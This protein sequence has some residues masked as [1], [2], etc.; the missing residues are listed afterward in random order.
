MNEIGK[1]L[2][3]ELEIQAGSQ[4]AKVERIENRIQLLNRNG[5]SLGT[6]AQIICTAPPPQSA[7]LLVDFPELASRLAEIKLQPCWAVMVT[8]DQPLGIEWAGAFVHDS[9]IAWIGRESSKPGRSQR[10]AYVVHANPTWSAQ[11]LECSAEEV[12]ELILAEFRQRVGCSQAVPAHWQAH[13]WRYSIAQN[14]LSA[15][16][17]LDRSESIFACGDWAQGSRIE[18]AF[19]SGLAVAGRILGRLQPAV[20]PAQPTQLLMFE[21][22]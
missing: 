10:E 20:Q 6:Y 9:P 2:A 5:V 14:P 22:D 15:G 11:H 7:E 4:V 12:V 18:G 13:R 19:L 8:F 1:R 17:L 16:C 3:Q 21:N